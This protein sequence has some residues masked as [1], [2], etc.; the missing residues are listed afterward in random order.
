MM[1][2]PRIA[3]FVD[4]ENVTSAKRVGCVI[5]LLDEVGNLTSR[6]AYGKPGRAEGWNNDFIR[7]HG[8]EY[9]PVAAVTPSK[10]NDIVD[11]QLIVGAM[12]RL[13]RGEVDV[14]AIVSGDADYSALVRHARERVS[15]VWGFAL[16]GNSGNDFRKLFTPGR[17]FPIDR[18]HTVEGERD[19]REEVKR[20]AAG[21]RPLISARQKAGAPTVMSEADVEKIKSVLLD[22]AREIT[23]S[24][25]P[26]AAMATFANSPSS[27][28]ME[29]I[30]SFLVSELRK[31]DART[32]YT[33][34]LRLAGGDMPA[35]FRALT[36]ISEESNARDGVLLS[37]VVVNKSKV[38]GPGFFVMAQDLGRQ[39]DIG[40]EDD[41]RRMWAEELAKAREWARRQDDS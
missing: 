24:A 12:D 20:A 14:L 8:L 38:P 16:S 19:M 4:A 18:A 10:K 1:F 31:P 2:V 23:R 40:S 30:R 6:F 41:K 9:V 3:L 33:Q 35:L 34:L 36:D 39:F 5:R 25:R 27:V 26:G 11:K 22:A 7:S 15:E 32:H 29:E 37:A 21:V 17:F 13:A 28:D